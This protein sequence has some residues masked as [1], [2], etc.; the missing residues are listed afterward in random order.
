MVWDQSEDGDHGAVVAV[1]NVGL[2]CVGLESLHQSLDLGAVLIAL[3][4]GDD[5]A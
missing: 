1:G 2:D 3:A 4:A 5:V